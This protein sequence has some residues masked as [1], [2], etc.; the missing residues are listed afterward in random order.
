[1]KQKGKFMKFRFQLRKVKERLKL[2][3]DSR[4]I[5]SSGLFEREWYLKHNSD[6][7]KAGVDPARHYVSRGGFEGRRPGPNFDS[8]WYLDAYEDVRNSGWNPLV[9]FLK[10]GQKEERKPKPPLFKLSRMYDYSKQTNSIIFEESPERIFLRRPQVIG[11]FDGTLNEGEA[12]C[13]RPY[14]SV[15]ENAIIFGGESLVVVNDNLI[16]ND[17]LVDFAGR[18]F[19]K[20]TS[21]V[22]PYE[23]AVRLTQY[24]KPSLY[25]KEGVLLSCGHD[26]N[27]FHWLAECLP[28]LLWMDSLEQFNDVPLLIPA[29]LHT[30]LMVALKRL[31]T[32]NRQLIYIE[33]GTSCAVERLIVPSALSRIVDRYEGSPVFNVDIVLSHTWLT[34][35]SERLKENVSYRKK[36]WRKIFLTRRKGIRALGNRE[37]I[38]LMLLEQGFE[39]VELE[40]ASL[41][42]Q[43]ELFSEASMVVAPTGAALTNMLFCR[44]GTK[45]I[46][47]MSNHETTNFYFWSNLGAINNLDITTIAGERLFK[48]TD[49]WSVHDD[50][51]V[52]ADLVLEEIVKYEITQKSEEIKRREITQK[53][54]DIFVKETTPEA[55]K[56]ATKIFVVGPPRSGT[57]LI[58]SMIAN[59]LF[60]PECTFVSNLMKVFDETYRF[61][62]KERFDYYGHN[63]ENLVEVFKKPVFDFLYTASS[64]VGGTSADR[65]IYKDPVLT[66]YLEYFPLF[67][68]DSYKVVFCVRDPRDVVSSM[69]E[70]LK[71]QNGGIDDNTLFDKAT[72]LIF[73]YY[74]IIHN[75]DNTA[76]YID[77]HNIIFVKYEHIVTGN[78]ETIL[79]LRNFLRFAINLQAVNENI[80]GKLDEASPFYSEN[81]GKAL[82]TNPIG[83]HKNS[84]T[85]EQIARIEYT[86]SYYLERLGYG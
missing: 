54:S 74:Q 42:F 15:I 22:E 52:D 23:D 45:V 34:K 37:Q 44:P 2:I 58:Y 72:N 36:P 48:L 20:K 16:L 28:K 31:N 59:E 25:I 41:D 11:R 47:F 49:Y 46:I 5:E 8:R 29:G 6:V 65:F 68:D 18:E 35:V 77:K 4:L 85:S 13:P 73:P 62:D 82:T 86:F 69:F 56:S 70:V 55:I 17:E 64:K 53:S 12:L 71:K 24:A 43:I 27:Y 76:D 21:R 26:A 57:T 50:Y 66:L 3:R 7:A 79:S 1:V 10:Y 30:N 61:S 81:Y 84:L 40:G 63:L 60:L 67:F 38:E 9:H 32:H 39:I 51:V 19:G 83:G 78:N 33:T 75:I 14:V 80:K